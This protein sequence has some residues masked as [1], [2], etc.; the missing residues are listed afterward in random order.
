MGE[1][2][3]S[4]GWVAVGVTVLLTVFSHV[5]VSVWWA[6]KITTTLE[7]MR[8]T[9]ERMEKHQDGYY[10]KEEAVREFTKVGGQLVGMWARIDEQRKIL[11]ELE[12]TCYMNH[13]KRT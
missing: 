9:I 3:S 4:V 13:P 1:I 8:Q 11:E 2:E 10:S 7:F 12:K 5:V 6:S